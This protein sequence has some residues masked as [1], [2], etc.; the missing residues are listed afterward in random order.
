M[1]EEKI[2][3]LL[4][5]DDEAHAEI[6]CRVFADYDSRYNLQV[7]YNL[8][9]AKDAL[10]E[11]PDL[12]IADF[13]LPDG[14]GLE[15]L[16]GE[17]EKQDYPVIIM[18]SYGN[19][20]VAVEAIKNGAL[21]YVVKSED[22]LQDMPHIVERAMREWGLIKE[23][24]RAREEKRKLEIQ[25]FQSQK[26]EAIGTLAGGIAHDFNNILGAI[27]GYTELALFESEED[28][29]GRYNMEQVLKA[30][31]RA[32]DL[33]K[34]IL[35]FS[36]RS[37]KE[38]KN[39]NLGPLIG[40]AVKLLRASL[41]VS[42]EIRYH[43]DKKTPPILADP[44]QIH[45]VI[46]NLCTNA[47]HAME[48]NGGL[49]EISLSPFIVTNEDLV[50]FPDATPGKHVKIIVRD[51]GH[52][53]DDEVRQRIFD[54]YFT[55]KPQGKGTGLGLAVVHGI[56]RGHE[57]HIG[58]T[59]KP[60]SGTTFE[61]IFPTVDGEGSIEEI[62]NESIIPGKEHILFV[63]DEEFLVDLGT[64]ILERFGYRVTS[65][66]DPLKAIE[67]FQADPENFDMLVTDMS[68]PGINGKELA[69]RIRRIRSDIPI[70]ICSGFNES[71]NEEN[72]KDSG[73]QAFLSKPLTVQELGNTVRRILDEKGKS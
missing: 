49:L 53:M 38:K 11:S 25:L 22:A 39:V 48:E 45:Q 24:E 23:N 42:I 68:M 46:M 15:L 51:T 19:E 18:T 69:G 16:E 63:D 12:L 36:R 60:G 57:G 56:V 8:S 43:V 73:I 3:V 5:E 28:S 52:G 50:L 65:S 44:G 1:Q 35:A 41:P 2:K 54:P 70:I 37:D 61:I 13:L 9:E 58:L 10:G 72:A 21:D 33:V 6:I 66:M 17:M 71:I 7:A 55:T 59:T 4:V 31:H 34:Q 26:L 14:R 29:I 40:E 27:I 67:I 30:S 62:S 20:N 64:R 47:G 32:K